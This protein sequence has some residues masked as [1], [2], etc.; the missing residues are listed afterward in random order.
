MDKAVVPELVKGWRWKI[1][2][3]LSSSKC[4][5]VLIQKRSGPFWFTANTQ[6]AW[7]YEILG[8]YEDSVP[9]ACRKAMRDSGYDAEQRQKEYIR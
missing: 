4:L 3:S 5:H 6:Y 8:Y 7:D 9:Q 1:R 2:P